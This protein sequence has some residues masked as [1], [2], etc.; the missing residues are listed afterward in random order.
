MKK[1]IVLFSLLT[2]FTACQYEL[3]EVEKII[4]PD[5][6]VELSFANDILP[7]LTDHNCISCHGIGAQAPDLTATNAYQSLLGGYVMANN[8]EGSL[9][10]TYLN[11]DATTHSWEVLSANQALTIYTWIN[12]GAKNN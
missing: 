5:P 11:P 4:P 6:T 2:V 10:Y 9:F 8:P 3:V 12:Q 7:I 1:Y